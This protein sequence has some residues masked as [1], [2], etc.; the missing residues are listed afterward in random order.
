MTFLKRPNNEIILISGQRHSSGIERYRKRSDPT[1]PEIAISGRIAFRKS[2]DLYL[3][4]LS[5]FR[6]HF[7]IEKNVCYDDEGLKEMKSS[8]LK[9]LVR[10]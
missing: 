5:G 7:P 2:V 1:L 4:I 3:S 9:I 8:L 10:H 6:L